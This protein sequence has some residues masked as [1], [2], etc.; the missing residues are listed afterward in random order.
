[1]TI[2]LK[3]LGLNCAAIRAFFYL[4]VVKRYIIQL[5]LTSLTVLVSI[6]VMG[7]VD[8]LPF[9]ISAE[10]RLS[11]AK[12][13]RKK[14]GFNVAAIPRF[15]YDP[16]QGVGLGVDA[17]L[18]NNGR[19]DDPFFAYTPYR[20]RYQLSLWAAQNGK[21]AGSLRVDMPYVFDT[22]W[23][24]RARFSF[25]DNP[26]KLYFGIG[27]STLANLDPPFWDDYAAEL[28]RALPGNPVFGED[29]NLLYTDRRFHYLAYRKF[30]LDLI[31][32]RSYLEGRLRIIGAVGFTSL[33]YRHYDGEP[34]EDATDSEGRSV[35]AINRSTRIT[36]DAFDTEG[37]WDRF[38]VTGYE[39]GFSSKLKFGIIYDTRDFEPDPYKGF[40]VEYG[41]GLT[42]PLIGSDFQYQRHMLQY[43]QF[44]P[45]F[46]YGE[47]GYQ[48]NLA[49]RSAFSVIAG[50]DLF[51][52]EVYDVWSASQGRIGLLG[53]EDNL[54]GYKKFRFAAPVYGFGSLEWRTQLTDF[55][56]LNQN[57]MISAVP[58]FD[59]GRVWDE[60]PAM[61][62]RDFKYNWGLGARIHWNQNTI[63]R[64][65][66]AIS[67][68]DRQ[69][70]L[71]FG[72]MF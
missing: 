35:T 21:V 52:R 29:P 68:E 58:F 30:A 9:A 1:M 47:K 23:R 44:I 60:I 53:G 26:N 34:I 16:I 12:L 31:M 7:Q 33:A 64:L 11:D 56:F 37:S 57:W 40:L 51:F 43:L 5:A 36:Q 49:L 32:E 27:E 59:Y 70:F 69:F 19:R 62:L 10:K 45:L 54:R 17:E 55:E 25:A 71:I 24:F 41:M 38:N 42:H 2:L 65:D 6:D 63:I 48:S 20:Q 3:I 50:P 4:A 14:E 46:T 18:F 72:Q 61:N 8:S 67:Q 15:A 28:N 22:R 13:G 66:Y 39:G